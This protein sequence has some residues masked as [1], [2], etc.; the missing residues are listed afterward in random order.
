MSNGET[1][2]YVIEDDNPT[3]RKPNCKKKKKIYGITLEAAQ[4]HLEEWLE[5]E[6]EVTTH[7]SYQ[8]ES[9]ILTMADLG[10]IRQ[11]IEYWDAKVQQLLA[12]SETGGRNRMYRAVPRDY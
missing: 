4:M 11:E 5:A 12:Q 2:I 6:L 10:K 9:K 1:D 7:Q 8:I 3:G